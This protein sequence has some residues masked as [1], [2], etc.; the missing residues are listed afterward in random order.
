MLSSNVLRNAMR[1][2]SNGNAP[3]RLTIQ[4]RH[5]SWIAFEQP[6]SSLYISPAFP[7][8][9]HKTSSPSTVGSGSSGAAL[10]IVKPATAATVATTMS[11]TPGVVRAAATTTGPLS[12]TRTP[13]STN[14]SIRAVGVRVSSRPHIKGISTIAIT[15]AAGN[16]AAPLEREDGPPTEAPPSTEEAP[17]PTT[18]EAPGEYG[19]D[20]LDRIII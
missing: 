3:V 7:V 14:S 15:C 6:N 20:L 12:T 8:A 18:E 19:H 5:T 13:S 9:E 11:I 17:H 16:K 4:C 10:H 1:N 2:G